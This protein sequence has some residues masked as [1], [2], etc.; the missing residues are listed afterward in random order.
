MHALF[1]MVAEMRALPILLVVAAACGGSGATTPTTPRTAGTELAAAVDA[2][3]PGYLAFRP[4]F[5]VDLGLHEYDG[6]VP[7]RSPAAI[8][9]EIRRLVEAR[10]TFSRIDDAK[11]TKRGR[12]ERAMV[13]TE[14]SK[15]LFDLQIRRRP[16]RDPFYYL[17]K[18]SLNGYV[19]REY[20]DEVSRATAM[21][22]AC[23]AAPAYYQ[24]AAANLESDLPKAWLQASIMMSGGTIDFLAKDA[25]RTFERMP[26]AA[27]RQQLQT[28]LE[29]LAMEVGTFRDALKA[30]MATG[31]DDF[32]LGAENL[33]QML[34]A[35]EGITVD[36][37]TLQRIATADL[38]RNRAAI[39]EAARAID[40][41]KDVGAVVAAASADK[42]APDQV[43]QEAS[44][45]LA[46]L[47]QFLVDKQI[48]SL[49][50]ADVVEVRQSPA[51]MRGNFAAFSGVGPA[52]TKPLPS[53]Y[54]IAP[55]D[56]A[57]PAEQQRAYVM[58][59][60]DLLFTSVH[61][62]Y[63]GHFIQGMHQRASGSR[64][65]QTFETYLAS[66]GWAHYVEEMMWEQS[67]SNGDPRVHIGQ[68]K[69][70][71]LRD[72]RF[73]VALGFH[74]GTMTV[75]EATRLFVDQAFADPKTAMQQAMRG[76][77]DPMFLGYTLGKLVIMELRADWTKAH[78][79]RPI[80]E[81]HDELLSYGEAPLGTTR[82]LMLGDTAA[83]PLSAPPRN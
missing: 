59:R 45:Q 23:K 40:P 66:E 31:T 49:P 25:A 37:P 79:G 52:E 18:F 6:K 70:A 64:V 22:T 65:L 80:R 71:L 42:P 68:L 39:I 26:D 1:A 78:P 81:F 33:V 24:Q 11:L 41:T 56:P 47:R 29:A 54:Y 50:R 5:A 55:P 77:V 57:W 35:G 67:L 46:T 17:F 16:Y 63:P 2:F 75:E 73:L 38:E 53:F 72:V 34:R 83:P 28:C 58:S 32:R 8:Q 4:S 20:A 74:A 44:S 3:M 27:L 43:L 15:E 60:A 19:A 69:N 10:E 61:E 14:I 30:R 82:K 12:A 21:L 7:D 76:T 13:L 51:F 62:V 36:V 48:V 9:A